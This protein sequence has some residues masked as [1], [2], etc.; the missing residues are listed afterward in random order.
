MA[1]TIT[2]PAA[3]IADAIAMRDQIKQILQEDE[4]AEIATGGVAV[5][6]KNPARVSLELMALG[7]ID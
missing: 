7:I 5:R 2:I 4:R 6:T 1:V 3:G